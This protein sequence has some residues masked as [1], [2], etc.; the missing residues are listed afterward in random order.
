MKNQPNLALSVA[1][2][3][4]TAITFAALAGINAGLIG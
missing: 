4:L 2:Y 3:A 1:L